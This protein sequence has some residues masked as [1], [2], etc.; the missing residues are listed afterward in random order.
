MYRLF[1]E[2]SFK[3]ASYCFFNNRTPPLP[4]PNKT[5]SLSPKSNDLINMCT[6]SFGGSNSP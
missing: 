5:Y 4:V 3:D 1:L 2:I 6:F